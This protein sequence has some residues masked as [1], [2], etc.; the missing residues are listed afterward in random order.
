M[1]FYVLAGT[2]TSPTLLALTLD[3]EAQTA[4]TVMMTGLVQAI[5]AGDHVEFEPGYRPGEGEIV[6]LSS[7]ELSGGLSI[8]GNA[9]DAAVLHAFDPAGVDDVGLR[10]I[11]AIE[12]GGNQPAF[13]AFQRIEPRYVLKR[14]RWRLM[15]ADGRFVRDERPGLEIAERVDA[16]LEGRTLYAV[17]WPR[18]HATLDLTM[19]MREATVV[20]M[21]EFVEHK[22]VTLA[23]GFDAEALADT[24]VRRKIASIT[25]RKLLDKCSVQTLRQYAV[26]FGLD[27]KVSK[28]RIVLPSAKKDFKAVLGLLDEDLLSFEPTSERWVANSKR[29]P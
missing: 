16:L 26:N 28:G 9:S 15:F 11:A 6:T 29:R 18:A 27:L 12:W 23:D 22:K 8:L 7:F 20:E 10:A 13:I 4:L 21:R 5:R 19:W 2:R 25:D 14:E 1:N 3:N 17:S 24:A